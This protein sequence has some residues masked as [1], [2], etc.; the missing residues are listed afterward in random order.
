MTMARRLTPI[1]LA[2][3]ACALA[4]AGC[5]SPS[6][7]AAHTTASTALVIR[8][9]NGVAGTAVFTLRCDPPGGTVPDARRV[10]AR[11]LRV[12]PAVLLDPKGYECPGTALSP[13]TVRISG[14]RG[15]RPVHVDIATCWTPQVR[16]IRTLGISWSRVI[17]TARAGQT[18]STAS[19]SPA[20]TASWSRA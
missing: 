18:P 8:A 20:A 10:C 13:W 14:H 15:D 7:G 4:A 2:A 5:G 3:L 1:L 17:Q 9:T 19:I 16:L 12:P 6:S 11:L